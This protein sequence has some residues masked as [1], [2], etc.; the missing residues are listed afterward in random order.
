MNDLPAAEGNAKVAPGE[1][2]RRA[3]RGYV[4]QYDLGARV[5][6]QALAAGLL[7]W[8]GLA[9]RGAADFDDV[10]LRLH[11][12]IAAYQVKTSRDPRP[13]S[14]RTILLGAENLLG[15]MLESRRKLSDEHPDAL[16][17]TIYACD[18]YPRKDD[19][20]AGNGDSLSSAAFV[21]AHGAHRL[22]WT[23]ENWRA[24]PFGPFVNDVQAAS[25]LD[26][27]SFDAFSLY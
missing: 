19:N 9:D 22:S 2:E 25:G 12:R 11:D 13:F 27:L 14:I 3:Q 15:R 1:G 21:R 10:V 5:V 16:I 18:N 7:R 24:S 8:V 20:L 23:L 6:H 4:A 26:D 17:E